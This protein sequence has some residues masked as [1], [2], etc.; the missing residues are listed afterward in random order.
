MSLSLQIGES[1]VVPLASNTGYSDVL[2]WVEGLP[3]GKYPALRQ[4]TD[5]G[6]SEAPAD[7]LSDLSDAWTHHEN[8]VPGLSDTLSNLETVLGKVAADDVISVTDGLGP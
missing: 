1:E 3:V 2:D 6:W 8:S 7:V 5:W 4:L